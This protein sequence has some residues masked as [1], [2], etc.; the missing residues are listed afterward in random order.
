VET[1]QDPKEVVMISS[2][3]TVLD[4]YSEMDVTLKFAKNS[5]LLPGEGDSPDGRGGDEV[6]PVSLSCPPEAY[7]AMQ[8]YLTSVAPSEDPIPSVTCF[9]P[10]CLCGR[11]EQPS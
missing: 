4:L 1:K 3:L 10:I 9:L 7:I 5:R 8:P 2:F 11:W 6:L